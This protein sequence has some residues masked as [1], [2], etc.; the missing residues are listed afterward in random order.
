MFPMLPYRQLFENIIRE[1]GVLESYHAEAMIN[2]GN[3]GADR[4]YLI[5]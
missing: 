2:I 4:A 1:A 3:A 5:L